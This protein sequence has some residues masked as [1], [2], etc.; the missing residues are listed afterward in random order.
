MRQRAGIGSDSPEDSTAGAP[1]MIG[2]AQSRHGALCRKIARH[3]YQSTLIEKFKGGQC[4]LA[5][6]LAVPSA[7]DLSEKR[8]KARL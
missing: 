6:G 1:A 3:R 7:R 5:K 2:C 4:R 8:G